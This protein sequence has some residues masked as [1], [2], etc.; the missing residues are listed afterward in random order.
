MTSDVSQSLLRHRT[1]EGPGGRRLRHRRTS[2]RHSQ[3]QIWDNPIVARDPVLGQ[4]VERAV[5][6]ALRDE[7]LG[8]VQVRFSVWRDGSRALKFVCKVEARGDEA[9][10]TPPWRWW[11]SL[12]R[13]ADQLRDDLARGLRSRRERLGYTAVASAR[14]MSEC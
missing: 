10:G 8:P 7:D 11:S 2:L 13:R 14:V 6:E 9:T 12:T 5:D 4:A 3:I 1:G